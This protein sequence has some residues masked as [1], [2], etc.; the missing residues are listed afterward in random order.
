LVE[1][2]IHSLEP[3]ANASRPAIEFRLTRVD[4]ECLDI[5]EM[6]VEEVK[7][8]KTLAKLIRLKEQ[9]LTVQL[10]DKAL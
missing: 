6:S 8:L 9:R 3:G 2:A 10:Q 7:R 5:G 1:P 4:G